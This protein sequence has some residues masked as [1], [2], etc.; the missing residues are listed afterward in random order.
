[1]LWN[2]K[3]RFGK[4]ITA[5][6]LIKRSGFQKC[7]IVTHRSVVDDGWRDDFN[8]VFNDADGYNYCSKKDIENEEI[9]CIKYIKTKFA[10]LLTWFFKSYTR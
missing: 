2:A 5:L 6:E 9:A 7:I 3:M 1:M 8:K 4:T 10:R